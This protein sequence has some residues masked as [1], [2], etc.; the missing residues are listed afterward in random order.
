MG[1]KRNPPLAASAPLI[2]GHWQVIDERDPTAS[3][4]PIVKGG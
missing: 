4:Q 2:G 1:C 3:Q